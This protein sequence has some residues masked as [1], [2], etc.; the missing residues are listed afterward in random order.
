[1]EKENFE[2]IIKEY[3]NQICPIANTEKQPWER[4]VV[5][6]S[7]CS[8][9]LAAD[10]L[11]RTE[12]RGKLEP[13]INRLLNYYDT[14]KFTEN[15]KLTRRRYEALIETILN[16]VGMESKQVGFSKDETEKTLH[17]ILETLKNWEKNEGP[18]KSITKSIIEKFLKE[19]KQVG[20][21]KSMVAKIAEN[22]E[23][24]LDEKNLM[25]SF[26][27]ALKHEIENNVYYKNQSIFCF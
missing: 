20:L 18:D 14:V 4:F 22:V 11:L 1:M 24:K 21:G 3:V 19:L 25:E 9:Q 7:H 15:E 26:I 16:L 13:I 10:S 8:P 23:K 5:A 17:N 27:L 6:T 2:K 12:F